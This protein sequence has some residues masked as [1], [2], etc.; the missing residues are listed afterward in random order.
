MNILLDKIKA[1]SLSARK[2]KDKFL[3]SLLITLISEIEIVG[4]NARN[5]ETTETE[6]IKVIQKFKKNKVDTI[7]VLEDRNTSQDIMI[8]H[9]KELEIY[10]SYLPSM[11]SEEVLTKK[12]K[13]IISNDSNVN[14]GKIMG[15]LKK[16]LNGT[17]DGAMAS[18]IAKKL[19]P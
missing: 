18:K 15:A 5:S 17:Y 19:L 8:L 16:E 1:N 14:I 12:I 6:T 13:D 7:K 10:E 3:S 11:L 4:K 9:Q 2:N